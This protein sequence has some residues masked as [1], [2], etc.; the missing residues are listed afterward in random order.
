MDLI[1]SD[2]D[3]QPPVRF[4]PG[5]VPPLLATEYTTIESNN[6]YNS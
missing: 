1:G 6:S 5:T 2:L 4:G 3:L